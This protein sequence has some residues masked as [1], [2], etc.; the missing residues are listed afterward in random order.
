MNAYNNNN[1]FDTHFGLL[2]SFKVWL[3]Y[4][5]NIQDQ[6]LNFSNYLFLT[7][8]KLFHNYKEKENIFLRNVNLVVKTLGLFSGGMATNTTK[9]LNLSILYLSRQVYI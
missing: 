2:L 5:E 4:R 7:F 9:H 6:F 3:G 1:N 8:L